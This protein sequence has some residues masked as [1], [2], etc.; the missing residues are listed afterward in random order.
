MNCPPEIAEIILGLIQTALLR[1]RAQGWAGNSACCGAEADH[2]HNLPALLSNFSAELLQFY[3][4]VERPAALREIG[5][6]E[7]RGYQ[8]L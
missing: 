6:E 7:L 3:W 1:I 4:E 2:V 5:A 8:E